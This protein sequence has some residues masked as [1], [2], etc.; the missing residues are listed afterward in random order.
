MT[1][2]YVAKGF[3]PQAYFEKTIEYVACVQSPGG[4]IAWF[5]DG[6]TDPWN[7]VE[8]AMALSIGNRHKQAEQAYDWLKD[9]QLENG[10]WYVSIKGPRLRT[11]VESNP[12][13]WLMLPL[14]SGT[15]I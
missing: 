6:I 9:W 14:E 4:D 3:Y 10:G 5:D 8:A 1:K 15:T 12:I 13:S 2:V 7:H 11:P